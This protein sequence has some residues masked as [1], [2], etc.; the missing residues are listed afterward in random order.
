MARPTTALIIDDEAHVRMY[1]RMLLLRQ[2]LKQVYEAVDGDHGI[3]QYRANRPDI[4]LLDVV[5]PGK[6]GSSV[7]RELQA[8]NPN[9]PVIIV[10]SQSSFKVVQEFHEMGAIAY[11]LKHAPYEQ[12][13]KMLSDALDLAGDLIREKAD[14][15]AGGQTS[16]K[17]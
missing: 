1:L 11:L 5:M 7:L 15:E 3:A 14:P 8:A 12:M 6:P 10:T 4:V 2:G 16:P 17:P 9:L 13:I